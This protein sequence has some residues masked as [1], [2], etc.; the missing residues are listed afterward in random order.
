[1]FALL[2]KFGSPVIGLFLLVLCYLGEW[3]ILEFHSSTE[4]VGQKGR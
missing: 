2:P 1:M 4:A 3:F